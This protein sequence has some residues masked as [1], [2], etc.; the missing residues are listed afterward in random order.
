MICFEV[1]QA[2]PSMALAS[3][4]GST[5][6]AF[7][8]GGIVFLVLR[9]VWAI[10]SPR[11]EPAVQPPQHTPSPERRP[12]SENRTETVIYDRAGNEILRLGQVTRDYDADEDGGERTEVITEY[13]ESADGTVWGPAFLI[14][15]GQQ[16]TVVACEACR[17]ELRR[18]GSSQMIW[19]PISFARRCWSCGHYFCGAH[20]TPSSGDNHIRCRPC[21]RRYWWLHHVLRPI[22]FEQVKE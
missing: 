11:R 18:R 15:D 8:A 9:S 2:Y 19:T 3:I 21:N 20:Y 5:L 14:K 16:G 17:R 1:I 6:I 10:R 7:V 13:R 22:F 4:G 12:E